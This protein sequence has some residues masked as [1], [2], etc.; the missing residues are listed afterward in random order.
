MFWLGDEKSTKTSGVGGQRTDVSWENFSA[1]KKLSS[2]GLLF[3]ILV[4]WF[5]SA[6][7]ST[8]LMARSDFQWMIHQK[9][10]SQTWEISNLW[11]GKVTC[12]VCEVALPGLRHRGKPDPER[13]LASCYF[14][15]H[16][17]C[18]K[19]SWVTQKSVMYIMWMRF[20]EW[21]VLF[22]QGNERLG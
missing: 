15:H 21:R 22:L 10:E 19:N 11:R 6:K 8:N 4:S 18:L 1:S 7:I 3:M 9:K 13:G 16:V 14:K 17:W 2:P 12:F 20:F 5:S